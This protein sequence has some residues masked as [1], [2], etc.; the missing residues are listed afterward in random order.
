MIPIR[1][2]LRSLTVRRT[3]TLA[4]VVG[5]GLVVFVF[6]AAS[7]LTKGVKK[8]MSLSG[9]SDVAIVTR[10]GSD[11]E[12]SS[13][14][15]DPQVGLIK[16]QQGVK[17]DSNGQAIGSG[18]IIVVA[19]LQKV[20]ATGVSNVQLR[21]LGEDGLRLRPNVKVVEGRAPKPGSDEV[22]VGKRIEGRFRGTKLNESFEV[23]KNRNVQVVG[24]FEDGGSSHESEVWLDTEVLKTSYGRQGVVSSVRVQLDSPSSFEAFQAAV[25]SDKRIQLQAQRE[26]VYYEKQSEGTSIFIS[27]IGFLVSFFFS[28]GAMIGATITMYGTIAHRTREIGTL[29][30]LGF[31][32]GAVLF[33]FLLESVS[34]TLAGGV[35]GIAAALLMGNVKFSMINFASWSEMCFTFEPT[36][37]VLLK[38]LIFAGSIGILGGFLPAIRASRISPLQ[39]MRG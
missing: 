1:Y 19:A 24:V 21:G 10:K 28:L 33:S 39:A 32:R 35:L 8:T 25:E 38:A 6:A 17:H 14:I 29:R 13:N 22:M 20:G 18:E 2:N 31:S 23:K 3:T 15:E 37:D 26:T 5:V 4:T 7:M 16:S 11:N 12:L 9:R 30:A 36:P 34:L 27:A